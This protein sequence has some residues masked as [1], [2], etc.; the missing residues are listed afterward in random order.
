M[1][2]G[3]VL[4]HG[5][6]CEMVSVKPLLVFGL[7][8]TLVERIHVRKVPAGMPAPDLS[9]GLAKV[10]L[11]PHLMETLLALQEHCRLAVWS[12]TTARNTAPLM[13]AVFNSPR[14]YAN[15]GAAAAAAERAEDAEGDAGAAALKAARFARRSGAAGGGAAFKPPLAFEFVWTREHT[16]VDDF[17]RVNAVTHEDEHATV[18]DLSQV[19]R[20]YPA[21]ATPENTILIDDTPSKAKMHAANYLWLETCEELCIQ[22]ESGLPEL[23]RFVEEVV[24]KQSDV[25]RVLPTR[26]RVRQ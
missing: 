9:V 2:A 23:R 10:W 16:S 11:R 19:F 18:K 20:T 7:R 1:R 3:R 21:I 6:K 12:S 25:R 26:I 13:E 5:T 24:L 22:R 14:Q 15:C 4:T 17:R 8:G